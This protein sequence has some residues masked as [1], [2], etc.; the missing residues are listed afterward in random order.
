MHF[1]EKLFDNFSMHI[2]NSQNS[3]TYGR[4][5]QKTFFWKEYSSW[6]IQQHNVFTIAYV[7]KIWWRF[8]HSFAKAVMSCCDWWELWKLSSL[9]DRSKCSREQ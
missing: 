9:N 8:G 2:K 3:M 4:E 6:S 7:Q 5:L 1:I